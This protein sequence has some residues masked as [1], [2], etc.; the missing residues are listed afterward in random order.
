MATCCISH[1]CYS[2]PAIYHKKVLYDN[3]LYS[4]LM[5]MMCD[6]ALKHPCHIPLKGVIWQHAI[7]HA[8]Y[9][10]SRKSCANLASF[11]TPAVGLILILVIRQHGSLYVRD[12]LIT[13]ILLLGFLTGLLGVIDAIRAMDKR[14][15][16]VPTSGLAIQVRSEVLVLDTRQCVKGLVKELVGP[17][18]DARILRPKEGSNC[19]EGRE[20]RNKVPGHNWH[21]KQFRSRF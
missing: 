14:K 5:I 11:L 9:Q 17:R 15:P 3:V 8:I 18:G 16:P 6:I 20:V 19:H 7:C 1:M 4:T 2:T 13:C 10:G 12:I 21:L